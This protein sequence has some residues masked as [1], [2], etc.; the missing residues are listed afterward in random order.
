[1]TRA[2]KEALYRAKDERAQRRAR[3]SLLEFTAYTKKDYEVNWHHRT[4][5][6]YLDRFIAGDIK[7][8]I[9]IM[10]PRHGKSEL[11]S[12]RLP[13]YIYGKNPD[14]KIIACSYSAD[15]ARM[16][17]RDC[18]RIMDG[19]EYQKLFPETQLFGKNIRTVA[20]G[21]A[22]RN[23][24]IFEIV[25]K[26]GQY[27]AAGV[28]GGITGMGADYAIIDDPI[29]NQAEADSEVFRNNVW[30][31][32]TSTLYTR[33]EKDDHVLLTLTRWHEDDL[34]GRLLEQMRTDPEADKWVVLHFPAMKIKDLDH[35]ED[36]R[37]LGE[38]LWPGKY[39]LAR[40]KKIKATA[41]S[42]VWNSLYQGTP[43]GDG[44]NIFKRKD[45][46][47]YK[48]LPKYRGRIIQSWDTAF[49]DKEQND[50]SV[51]VTWLE[52]ELGYY[53]LNVFRERLEFPELIK[54]MKTL[55]KKWNPDG[56]FVEDKA[57]GQSAVQTI[58]RK[59]KIPIIPR[60]VDGDKVARA[61]AQTP[62]VEAGNVYL[63][64]DG[65]VEDT[66]WVHDFLKE[67]TSFP[68]SKFDDQVD[69]FTIGL[70]ELTDGEGTWEEEAGY[71][72][73]MASDYEREMA[74]V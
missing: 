25:D 31:W 68:N 2:S 17:N 55:F 10:P 66:E 40:L 67:L 3:L 19:L 64:E 56:V 70:K 12:R 24:E 50:Y 45:F 5:C 46:R 65:A 72:T 32:Y 4:L 22:L 49:K 14:A 36:P 53:V 34:A 27:R 33:L 59:T 18:Q 39:D 37:K 13:A 71:G 60:S 61:K 52:S 41:G 73:T 28:G 9:V 15:L 54:T 74:N 44:G 16:M 57:S 63:P 43:T 69:G 62:H 35:S 30:D 1:M 38:P 58:K 51:C 6:K 48:V 26:A 42:Y 11:V 20:H 21:T 47:W 23:S 29:K 8:L 7:R